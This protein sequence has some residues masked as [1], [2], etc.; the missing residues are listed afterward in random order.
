MIAIK[1]IPQSE[2]EQRFHAGETLFYAHIFDEQNAFNFFC[3]CKHTNNPFTTV[4][5]NTNNELVA[6]VADKLAIYGKM[7]KYNNISEM[8]SDELN[9]F[10]KKQFK[11]S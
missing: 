8:Y 11:N 9:A 7:S 2:A 3:T 6:H 4:Y 10:F 1:L 5:F